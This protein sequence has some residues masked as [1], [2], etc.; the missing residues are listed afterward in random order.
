[1]TP[2]RLVFALHLFAVIAIGGVP[3]KAQITLAGDPLSRERIAAL[4]PLLELQDMIYAARVARGGMT[5]AQADA[6][7]K[8][9]AAAWLRDAPAITQVELVQA[10]RGE[11]ELLLDY[12]ALRVSAATRWPPDRAADIYKPMAEDRLDRLGKALREAPATQTAL[13]EILTG[14]VEIVGWTEGRAALDAALDPFAASHD[15][16]VLAAVPSSSQLPGTK[17]PPPRP[18]A[19]PEALKPGKLT[20]ATPPATKPVSPPPPTTPPPPPV[21]KPAVPNPP[22]VVAKPPPAPPPGTL[23]LVYFGL[24]DDR[25]G[26]R[27]ASPSGKP[28]GRFVL[29]IDVGKLSSRDMTH[30][31]LQAMDAN[32]RP[33]G[34]IWH[35]KDPAQSLLLVVAGDQWLNT[36]FVNGLATLEGPEVDLILFA[37]NAPEPTADNAF[38]I[39]VGFADGSIARQLVKAR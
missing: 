33:V 4:V 22:P 31:A 10:L 12:A 26:P 24:Y 36:Q 38:I 29:S 1:M 7:L 13:H 17:P 27:G 2:L 15:R 14:T 16:A 5:A 9:Q 20:S 37:D 23:K 3:A 32:S 6:A 19:P 39:E 11:A 30:I 21:A 34:P 35:T 28:D 18:Q 8:A 25:V